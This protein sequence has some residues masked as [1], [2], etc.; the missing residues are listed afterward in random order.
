MTSLQRE[1]EI[2]QRVKGFLVP[3]F[4]SEDGLNGL[5]PADFEKVRSGYACANCLAEFDVY[6]LKCPLCGLERDLAADIQEAP[7]LWVD[8]I[9]DHNQDRTP[10]TTPSHNPFAEGA[11][12][13]D[14][15]ET[16]SISKLKPSK[17][18]RGR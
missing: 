1:Q 12:L 16:V 4:R 17:R 15:I 9:L 3:I 10:Y 6:T 11:R 5:G 14:D 18:G 2:K 8:D 13:P 7:Q